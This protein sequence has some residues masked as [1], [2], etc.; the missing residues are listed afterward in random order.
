[1]SRLLSLVAAGL[2]LLFAATATAETSVRMYGG[3]RVQGTF[4]TNHNF[5]GWN[6]TGTQTQDTMTLWQ[7]IRLHTD[8]VANE[9]LA[10]RLAIRAENQAWGELPDRGHPPHRP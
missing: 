1:M 9:N 6:T 8:F 10:F 5:T 4:L 2:F 3:F 7:R